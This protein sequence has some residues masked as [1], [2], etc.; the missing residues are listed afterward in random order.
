MGNVIPG[1]P[2]FTHVDLTISLRTWLVGFLVQIYCSRPKMDDSALDRHSLRRFFSEP[3]HDDSWSARGIRKKW[4]AG[5]LVSSC[6]RNKWEIWIE[7]LS[8]RTRLWV[9]LE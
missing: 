5:V 4:I 7:G 6:A 9:T 8:I 3:C 1:G 2:T